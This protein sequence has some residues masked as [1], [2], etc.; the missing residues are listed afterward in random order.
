MSSERRDT[1]R[2]PKFHSVELVTSDASGRER[3]YPVTLRDTSGKGLG[4]M[5]IG[6]EVLNPKND[7]RLRD[8]GGGEQKIRI[9]W[10]KQV[11]DFV[12]MMGMEVADA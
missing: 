3:T 9:V 12:L 7:Y 6:K 8:S 1:A 5:Y 10:T 2:D 4:A 11:A